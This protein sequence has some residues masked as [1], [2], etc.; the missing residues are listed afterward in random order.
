M[1]QLNDDEAPLKANSSIRALPSV[2]R[3]SLERLKRIIPRKLSSKYISGTFPR[4]G[5]WM[6]VEVG[7]GE[8]AEYGILNRSL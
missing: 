6:C 4:A 1:N 8:E 3:V 2:V 7:K 5:G